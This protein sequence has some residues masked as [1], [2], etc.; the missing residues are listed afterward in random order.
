MLEGLEGK[1]LEGLE[2]KI[3]EGLERILEDKIQEEIKKQVG[4]KLK[5]GGPWERALI[6]T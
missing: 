6:S 1:I 2:G 5:G 4:I 3:L